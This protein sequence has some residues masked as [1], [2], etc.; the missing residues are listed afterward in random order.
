SRDHDHVFQIAEIHRALIKFLVNR[1]S[2][3]APG[4]LSGCGNDE[5][6]LILYKTREDVVEPEDLAGF[7]IKPVSGKHIYLRYRSE[8]CLLVKFGKPVAQLARV[9]SE[10]V[11]IIGAYRD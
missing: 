9:I 3:I 7:C 1:F 6:V 4:I 11:P 10:I 2:W 5:E 8:D